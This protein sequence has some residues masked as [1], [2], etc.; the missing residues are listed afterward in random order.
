MLSVSAWYPA[1]ST[2]VELAK[3]TIRVALPV[4]VVFSILQVPSS[5]RDRPMNV[6]EYQPVKLAAM[7]GVWEDTA[8]RAHDDRRLGR[9]GEPDDLWLSRSPAC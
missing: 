2:H 4:F 8:L 1:A 9:R 5:A 6:T 7:E 3:A